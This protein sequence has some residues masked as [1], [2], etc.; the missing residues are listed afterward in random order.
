VSNQS[1][2]PKGTMEEMNR[3]YLKKPDNQR[4]SGSLLKKVDRD[5]KKYYK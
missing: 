5:Q 1:L 4:S 2:D 3:K